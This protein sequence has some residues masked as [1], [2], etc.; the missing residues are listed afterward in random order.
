LRSQKPT[1]W[2]QVSIAL[3]A[4]GLIVRA[5]LYFPLAAFPI[6]SDGV[7]AGLCA[8]RIESGHL[9]LFF[10][11]GTRL[12]A[13]SCY[14]AATYFQ[15]LGPGR[16]GLALTG[17]TWGAAYLTFSLLYLRAMLGE[18]PACLAFVYAVIPS[19][20]FMT[21]TYVP[22][23]YGEIMASCAATLWLATLWRNHGS[24]WQRIGFGISVGFGLWI[25]MQ[26]LMV[27]LPAIVWIATKRRHAT[28]NESIPAILGAIAGAIPLLVGNFANGFASFTQNWASRPASSLPQV[29]DNVVWLVT[30]PFPQLLFYGFSG[31]WSISTVLIAGYV[32]IA[33]GFVLALRARQGESGAQI[34]AREAG[35]LLLLV[36]AVSTLLYVCSQAGSARGWTVRYI[37]PLYVI[38]PLFC[39]IG[40]LALLRRSRWLAAGALAATIA[41]NL[42][43]YSL[44]G[45]AARDVLATQLQTN[46]RLLGVLASHDVRLVYGD[47][48]QVYDLNFDSRE[49]VAGIPSVA[50]VDYLNYSAALPANGTR[51]AMLS[52]DDDQLRAWVRAMRAR[53]TNATVDD[54]HLFI[55][56]DAAPDTA[57]LLATLRDASR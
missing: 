50:E 5:A 54:L 51:W 48:F 41:P 45:S 57:K 27:A 26:T 32:L 16:A 46:A 38:V 21:V 12:S 10:P 43:L 4:V 37:A 29:W 30:T 6:D 7:L 31:W 36:L 17:L 19:Q 39:G 24:L 56:D 53:G 34:D 3:L 55:A 52:N 20:P 40:T 13:A 49:R 33:I 8:F 9:P 1:F 35:Q 44:P 11:G 22:W 42:L 2:L 18:R 47:Y 14:L 15:L 23:A 28:P 25:S